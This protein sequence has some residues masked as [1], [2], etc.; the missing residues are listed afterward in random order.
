MDKSSSKQSARMYAQ[1][2]HASA[3][4]QVFGEF[5]VL[6]SPQFSSENQIFATRAINTPNRFALS[7]LSI[8]SL[9]FSTTPNLLHTSGPLAVLQPHSANPSVLLMLEHAYP[10]VRLFYHDCRPPPASVCL[11]GRLPILLRLSTSSFITLVIPLIP[12]FSSSCQPLY[13]AVARKPDRVLG[14]SPGRH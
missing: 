5:R 13:L 9:H 2:C 14:M 11:S 4:T 8:G 3:P 10:G 1:I 6:P 12:L 7:T